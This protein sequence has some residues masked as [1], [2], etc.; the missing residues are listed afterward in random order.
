MSAFEERMSQIASEL[1]PEA[2]ELAALVIDAEHKRRFSE[3]RSVLPDEFAH[4]ALQLA[5]AKEE[6]QCSSPR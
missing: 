1:S 5:K 3:D 2:K 4:R 6:A